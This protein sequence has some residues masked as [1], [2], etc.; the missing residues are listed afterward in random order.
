[1]MRVAAVGIII[2]GVVVGVVAL[3]MALAGKDERSL[4]KPLVVELCLIA[5]VELSQHVFTEMLRHS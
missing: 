2:L 3:S 4:L 5:I 1:M